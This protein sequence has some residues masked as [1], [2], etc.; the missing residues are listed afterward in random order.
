MLVKYFDKNEAV[1]RDAINFDADSAGD[2]SNTL[3][4]FVNPKRRSLNYDGVFDEMEKNLRLFFD[5]CDKC[6]TKPSKQDFEQA[7]SICDNDE[8]TRPYLIQLKP[9]I[10]QYFEKYY[11]KDLM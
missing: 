4:Q 9:V 8:K 11:N 1:I 5:L 6:S 10:Q 7:L 3:T 2:N